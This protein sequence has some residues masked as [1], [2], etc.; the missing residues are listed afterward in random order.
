MNI[1]FL[2]PKANSIIRD[3]RKYIITIPVSGSKNVNN[4]GI[5]VIIIIIKKSFMSSFKSLLGCF[6]SNQVNI[7]TLVS[8][9]IILV[10]SLG[11][12]EPIPGIINQ[13]FEPF[14][15]VPKIRSKKSKMF[16]KTY[17]KID[18]SNIFLQLNFEAKKIIKK[19]IKYHI[20][21]FENICDPEKEI[22]AL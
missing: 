21:C 9:K 5:M 15:S 17:N 3:I 13:H 12:N 6:L 16:M 22:D 2:I 18:M 4:A 14:T 8:I 1:L 19:P 20:I 11:W 7:L 10:N